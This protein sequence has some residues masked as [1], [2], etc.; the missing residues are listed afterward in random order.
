MSDQKYRDYDDKRT[1]IQS[2][3]KERA[4]ENP[5]RTAIV[6]EDV[7][8]TYEQLDHLTDVIAR[9]LLERFQID[10]QS[11]VGVYLPKG[12]NYII[13]CL[14]IMKTGATYLHIDEDYPEDIVRFVLEESS[15]VLI[16][17]CD[18]L[19]PSL[20]FT[21]IP[22][23]NMSKEHAWK[24]HLTNELT[25]FAYYTKTALI[26]YTSGTTDRP[27]GV[28]VSHRA[29]IFS[30]NK[31]WEEIQTIPKAD[32]FGYITYLAWDAFSPLVHGMTGII[33]SNAANSDMILL[34]EYII[35]HRINHAFFTPSLLDKMMRTLCE[36]EIQEILETLAVIW[37]GG[38]ILKWET[39]NRFYEFT[40]DTVLLNNYGPTECFVVSQGRLIREELQ[41]NGPIHAGYILPEID[42]F[43]VNERSEII[44]EDGRGYLF[45]CGPALANKYLKADKLNREKF[46]SFNGKVY[47]NTGDFC[48]VTKERRITILGRQNNILGINQSHLIPISEIENTIIRETKIK[49]CVI[50]KEEDGVDSTLT[51]YTLGESK[52]DVVIIEK[53]MNH[54]ALQYR[55]VAIDKIPIKPSSQKIDYLALKLESQEQQVIKTPQ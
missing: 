40:S 30:F 5:T 50:I 39:M 20:E 21:R 14:S 24:D 16:L 34:K 55:I 8:F 54:Y 37:V 28:C 17:S 23:L 32:R 2:L 7:T 31:F 53:I 38:E 35:N 49:R 19:L 46:V 45:V 26:G 33:V 47:F 13:A 48:D 11:S 44:T 3:I 41:F 43:L 10:S 22:I 4:R 51:I 12:H 36:S 27:K 6:D 29:C 9:N 1:T 25:I 42:Y 15:P 52:D 18:K